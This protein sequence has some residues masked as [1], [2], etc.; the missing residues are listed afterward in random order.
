MPEEFSSPGLSAK[1]R[2]TSTERVAPGLLVAPWN[3]GHAT[4]DGTQLVF[5]IVYTEPARGI[6]PGRGSFKVKDLNVKDSTVVASLLGDGDD[7]VVRRVQ[8]QKGLPGSTGRSTLQLSSANESSTENLGTRK[9]VFDRPDPART[10]QVVE[11]DQ[12]YGKERPGPGY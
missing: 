1:A 4:A 6:S 7:S 2:S 9:L 8:A 11:P 3:L 12:N 10:P 5:D